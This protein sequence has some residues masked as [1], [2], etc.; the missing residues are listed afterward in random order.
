VVWNHLKVNNYPPPFGLT[1]I[2]W[3]MYIDLI[4]NK[5]FPEL[6]GKKT[7]HRY[8]QQDS[9]MTNLPLL[10]VSSICGVARKTTCTKQIPTRNLNSKKIFGK[11][12]PGFHQQNH[13]VWNR[14]CFSDAMYAYEH[15]GKCF[16]TSSEPVSLTWSLLFIL[17]PRSQW[18][19]SRKRASAARSMA[20]R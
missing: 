17:V 11:K 3:E 2:N 4:S 10:R 9:A 15:K 12:Y 16:N 1:T 5:L 8:F 18:P 6:I 14:A 7:L 13:N 19:G 20:A